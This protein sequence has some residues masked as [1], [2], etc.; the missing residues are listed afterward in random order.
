MMMREAIDNN[1]ITNKEELK[2]SEVYN[3]CYEFYLIK[4]RLNKVVTVSYKKLL[5]DYY[6]TED[7]YPEYEEFK[8]IKKYITL[9]EANTLGFNKDK[10]LKRIEDIKLMNKAYDKVYTEGFISRKDLKDKF[11]E[12]FKELGISIKPTASLIDNCKTYSVKSRSKRIDGNLVRGYEL[13]NLV[14]NDN[15]NYTHN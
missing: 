12:V 5:Q 1:L 9:K 6:T 2:D 15:T 3:K 11:T 4:T 8:E 13:N 7:D 14:F 10:L